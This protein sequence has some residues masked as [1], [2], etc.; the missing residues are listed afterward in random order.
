MIQTQQCD[1][2]ETTNWRAHSHVFDIY[3]RAACLVAH[4]QALFQVSHGAVQ[5]ARGRLGGGHAAQRVV[6]LGRQPM[7]LL[8]RLRE[9][10]GS[11]STCITTHTLQSAGPM[12]FLQSA[13]PM[14]CHSEVCLYGVTKAASG[15][16]AG[17]T[18]DQ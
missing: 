11:G 17:G 15:R 7:R 13:G 10:D 14:A 8:L 18:A 3:R 6:A 4:Q 5:R 2:A 12:V 9:Y 16:R 1:A